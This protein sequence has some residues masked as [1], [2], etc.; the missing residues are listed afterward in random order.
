MC[1][2]DTARAAA[3]RRLNAYGCTRMVVNQMCIS[4][5]DADDRV[6]AMLVRT[7]TALLEGGG[8]PRRAHMAL[9]QS[10]RVSSRFA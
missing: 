7:A 1:P 5:D 4:R 3:Q 9:M 6:Y 10:L 8:W 2:S